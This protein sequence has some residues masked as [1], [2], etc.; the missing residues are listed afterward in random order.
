MD[1]HKLRPQASINSHIFHSK[2]DVQQGTRLGIDWLG[3]PITMGAGPTD[4][5]A[6]MVRYSIN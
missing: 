6:I 4:N 2:C 3:G 1:G 5:E